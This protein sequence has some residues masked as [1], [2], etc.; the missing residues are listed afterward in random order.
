MPR[1]WQLSRAATGEMMA[2]AYSEWRSSHSQNRGALVWFFKDLWPAAG[3][4]VVDSSGVPKA[5][6]YFLRR[7]W[8]SRQITLTDEGLNG[9]HVHVT[10]ETAETLGGFVEVLLLKEPSTVVVRQE[11]SVQL[12]G[13]SRQ[14]LNVDEIVGGFY[15]VS[16]AYRFG[17]PH[18]DLVMAT[19]YD[20]D[21]RV[22]SEAFHFIRRRESAIVPTASIDAVAEMTSETTCQLTLSCDRFLHGVRL[23]AKGF[24][25]D[26]NYFHLAPQRTKIVNFSATGCSQREFK[27]EVEALNVESL[28]AIPVRKKGT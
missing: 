1:Y 25:A 7:L 28:Q 3:W 27:T 8:Q 22:L 4:G 6:Y 5:A 10:N 26:D 19:L 24:L 23:S 17:A 20:D 13:R 21:H 11:V 18:H 2:L 16:Y 9:L 12:K 15:D 14:F